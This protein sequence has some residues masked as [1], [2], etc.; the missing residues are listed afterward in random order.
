MSLEV[1]SNGKLSSSFEM[2]PISFP[3][4]SLASKRGKQTEAPAA[5]SHRDPPM[6]YDQTNTGLVLVGGFFS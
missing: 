3:R 2:E 4:A 5:V 6:K 1:I